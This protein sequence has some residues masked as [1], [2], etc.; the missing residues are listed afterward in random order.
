MELKPFPP[1][2]DGGDKDH[3]FLITKDKLLNIIKLK[4]NKI[5]I[6]K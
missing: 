2:Q 5:N 3:F 6:I 4:K 1:S